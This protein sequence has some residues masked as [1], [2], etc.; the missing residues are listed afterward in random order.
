[1]VP[2]SDY[3]AVTKIFAA[4]EKQPFA[5]LD[6][7]CC[8]IL[9]ALSKLFPASGGFVAHYE[10]GTDQMVLVATLPGSLLAG[11]PLP[12]RLPAL[13]LPQGTFFHIAKEMPLPP[14]QQWLTDAFPHATTFLGVPIYEA[15]GS[16]YGV[17]GMLPQPSFTFHPAYMAVVHLMAQRITSEIERQEERANHI[18]LQAQLQ[19]SILAQ[20][21]LQ[22]EIAYLR[23]LKSDMIFIINHKFRNALTSVKGFSEMLR[24]EMC[25]PYE[26]R[27]YAADIHTSSQHLERIVQELVALESMPPASLEQAMRALDQDSIRDQVLER[28]RSRQL[29]RAFPNPKGDEDGETSI[30]RG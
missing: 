24:D 21:T 10:H 17:L 11:R 7:A 19:Q 6:D 5:S 9:Q 20:Q 25:S 8:A 23:K 16:R 18:H 30:L 15:D 3:A 14:M 29:P 22:A 28:V 4:L 26:V 1:M 12:R 27:D 2:A 13:E